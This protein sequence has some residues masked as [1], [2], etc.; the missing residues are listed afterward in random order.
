MA[1][2][3]VR[4]I[5]EPASYNEEPGTTPA[6][7]HLE[8]TTDGVLWR[9]QQI[10]KPRIKDKEAPRAQGPPLKLRS[11]ASVSASGPGNGRLL[12]LPLLMKLL[13]TSGISVLGPSTGACEPHMQSQSAST[14]PPSHIE[15]EMH[16]SAAGSQD[17]RAFFI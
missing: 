9:S 6:S 11:L 13:C 5:C 17:I 8:E 12:D 3:E 10:P 1:T 14:A 15:L 4:G 16:L 2:H 7:W